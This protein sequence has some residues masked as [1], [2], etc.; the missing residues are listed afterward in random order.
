M[1]EK[2]APFR[3]SLAFLMLALSLFIGFSAAADE[4]PAQEDVTPVFV[5]GVSAGGAAGDAKISEHERWPTI[6]VNAACYNSGSCW[7][8]YARPGSEC[9]WRLCYSFYCESE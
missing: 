5:P 3:P 1:K 8:C 7:A 4:V 2:P 6:L 9:N